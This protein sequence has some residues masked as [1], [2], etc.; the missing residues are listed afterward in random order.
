MRRSTCASGASGAPVPQGELAWVAWQPSWR[1]LPQRNLV[2]AL[3][4]PRRV[5]RRVLPRRVLPP[6]PPP[7]P[8]PPPWTQAL[9]QPLQGALLDVVGVGALVEDDPAV[10]DLLFAVGLLLGDAALPGALFLLEGDKPPTRVGV[11]LPVAVI[12]VLEPCLGLEPGGVLLRADRVPVKEGL[13]LW[14]AV[15]KGVWS[16]QLACGPLVK[17]L[18]HPDPLRV[19]ILPAA[20]VLDLLED[21]EVREVA[22][23][24][25]RH[26]RGLKS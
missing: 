21:L 3:P 16:R 4:P 14:R 25:E 20:K 22:L 9:G 24:R 18:E 26:R 12:D 19:V 11:R 8:P 17:P 2:W 7:P 5:L 6:T 1:N 15:P 23:R 10:V 13:D